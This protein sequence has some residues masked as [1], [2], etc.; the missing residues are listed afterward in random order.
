MSRWLITGVA[1][2]IAFVLMLTGS[3][4]ISALIQTPVV[5]AGIEPAPVLAST[6]R[7]IIVAGPG[8]FEYPPAPGADAR[9]AKGPAVAA[10]VGAG[11]CPGAAVGQRTLQGEH[12]ADRSG[13]R[14]G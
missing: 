2:V 4:A 5:W 7:I 3:V 13:C 11:I 9:T 1:A 12:P 8:G 14:N 6:G 10:R